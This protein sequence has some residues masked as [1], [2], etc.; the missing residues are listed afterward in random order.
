LDIDFRLDAKG[1]G[2]AVCGIYTAC[3]LANRGHIVTFHAKHIEWFQWLKNI[4]LK[5][6]P[7]TDQTVLN[8]NSGYEDQLEAART[9][10]CASRSFWYMRN[11]HEKFPYIKGSPEPIR[12]DTILPI[13]KNTDVPD[14]YIVLAPFSAYEDRMYSMQHWRMLAKLLMDAGHNVIAIGAAKDGDALRDAFTKTGVR[15]YWGQPPQ[16]TVSTIRHSKLLIGNDSGP[17]HIAGLYGSKAIALCGQVS[18]H[19]VFHHS[20]SVFS[21]QPPESA[22]CSPCYWRK[23]GG[24]GPMCMSGCSALQIISPFQVAE[25]AEKIIGE[26]SESLTGETRGREAGL[27]GPQVRRVQQA[28]SSSNR[29][30]QKEDGAGQKGRGRKA[31]AVRTEGLPGLHAAQGPEAPGELPEALSGN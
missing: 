27:P 28:Y 3:G 1:I 17:A 2:D 21:V 12:P 30:P 6:V 13:E 4:N 25:L 8:A 7:E 23:S 20:P 16:W 22:K 10:E 15:F 19:F 18:G 24:Y 14:D 11:I 9:R 31:G 26:S 5:V 29:K